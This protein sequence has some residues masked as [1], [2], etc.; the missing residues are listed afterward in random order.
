MNFF[1][2]LSFKYSGPLNIIS[3]A[4]PKPLFPQSWQQ[5]RWMKC[6]CHEHFTPIFVF[7][8]SK[9]TGKY[10]SWIYT[11]ESFFL[12]SFLLLQIHVYSMASGLLFSWVRSLIFYNIHSPH[13]LTPFSHKSTHCGS[14]HVLLNT[15]I[16]F[17]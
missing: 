16:A 17:I 6:A 3:I 14:F 12:N 4:C 9:E 11:H 1:V 13:T 15:W 2:I 7:N 10:T 5:Y 8:P